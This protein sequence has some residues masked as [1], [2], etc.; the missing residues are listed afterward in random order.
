MTH[1]FS[2]SI[3]RNTRLAFP[4]Y[5][6]IKCLIYT[7]RLK[8]SLFY[9][10]TQ[11][12]L[13]FLIRSNYLSTER[14]SSFIPLRD[15]WFNGYTVFESVVKAGWYLRNKENRLILDHYD[16]TA[17]FKQESSFKVG[18]I[19]PGEDVMNFAK[20]QMRILYVMFNPYTKWM[21]ESLLQDSR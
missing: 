9:K 21:N 10:V 19:R 1:S 5:H 8:N 18:K 2:P 7:L 13:L 15:L 17:D 16:G 20:S 14:K 11:F 12:M 6:P 4:S 3:P